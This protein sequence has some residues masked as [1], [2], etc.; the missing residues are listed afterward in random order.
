MIKNSVSIYPTPLPRTGCDTGSIFK[1]STFVLNLKYSFSSICWCTRV[2]D[3]SLYLLRHFTTKKMQLMVSFLSRKRQV[4][5][6]RFSSLLVAVPL[7]NKTVWIYPIPHH[8]K[9]ATPHRFLLE[10]LSRRTKQKITDSKQEHSIDKEKIRTQSWQLQEK[11][12][13][14]F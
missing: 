13:Q 1:L 8:V 3:D 14:K 6:K 4:W 9:N 11:Y 7:L 5:I 2:Q 12:W 10:G